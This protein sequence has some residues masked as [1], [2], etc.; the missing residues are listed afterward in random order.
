MDDLRIACRKGVVHLGGIL[1][2]ESQH[3]I[4]LLL[5]T[6]QVALEEIVDQVR[7]ENLLWEQEKQ[8]ENE[9]PR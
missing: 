4:L 1:P 3:R 6:H 9:L 5:V 8:R 2:N 7:V